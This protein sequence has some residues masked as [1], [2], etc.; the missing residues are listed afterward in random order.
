MKNQGALL[1]A[2]LT[3]MFACGLIGFFL[4]RNTG[5]SK[6]EMSDFSQPAVISTVPADG[7]GN[8]GETVTITEPLMVNINTASAEKLDLLPGIGPVLAQRIIAY[9]EEH[10]PFKTVSELTLVDGIGVSTM[11]ELLAYVTVGD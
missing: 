2:M 3:G 11:E 9:R 4:G 1:L 10:G 6:I 5:H 8:T 7:T